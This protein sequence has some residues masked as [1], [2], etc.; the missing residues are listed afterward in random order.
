[1]MARSTRR[2]ADSQ[3]ARGRA[4]SGRWWRLPAGSR[5]VPDRKVHS[6][7]GCR[8]PYGEFR[9]DAAEVVLDARRLPM[10]GRANRTL[11]R[12]EGVNPGSRLRHVDE[13][14]PWSLFPMLETRGYGYRIVSRE[15]G[16][17]QVLI[18]QLG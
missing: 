13:I 17:V 9:D 7:C 16:D 11:A 14:I 15:A 12:M 3:P 18:W 2:G 1:M 8:D 5:G 10:A 4:G 6:R